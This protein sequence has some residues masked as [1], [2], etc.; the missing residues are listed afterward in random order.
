[1]KNGAGLIGHMK[2][3]HGVNPQAQKLQESGITKSRFEALEVQVEEVESE[4]SAIGRFQLENED[5]LISEIEQRRSE[6]KAAKSEASSAQ[7]RLS[8]QIE[9]LRIKL[10]GLSDSLEEI[11]L[12]V[13]ERRDNTSVTSA[14]KPGETVIRLIP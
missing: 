13:L 8:Q 7:E 11:K 4:L 9:M 14:A 10:T 2:F 12:V 5:V 3:A 6:I 1:M